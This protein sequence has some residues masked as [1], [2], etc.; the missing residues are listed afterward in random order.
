MRQSL[1]VIRVVIL[2][3][4]LRTFD[5]LCRLGIDFAASLLPCFAFAM[6]HDSDEVMSV[7]SEEASIVSTAGIGD[8]AGAEGTAKEM[9]STYREGAS[10]SSGA[11]GA[12]KEGTSASGAEGT[13]GTAGQEGSERGRSGTGAK[14]S[15]PVPPQQPPPRAVTILREALR[16]LG[17]AAP[18]NKLGIRTKWGQGEL[19]NLGPLP[20]FIKQYSIFSFD[21]QQVSLIAPPVLETTGGIKRP[22]LGEDTA[23]IELFLAMYLIFGCIGRGCCLIG[24]IMT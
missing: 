1:D 14:R 10:S 5:V 4:V 20:N 9:V 6:A 16:K 11:E 21:G 19:A 15:P 18:A 12:Y 24:C 8:A 22:L 23:G 7:A 17:G 2:S 13:A 3:L